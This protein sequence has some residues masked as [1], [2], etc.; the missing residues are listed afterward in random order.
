MNSLDNA[1]KICRVL[2]EALNGEYFPA[3]TGGCLYK[4]G[5][6]K[7]V[8]IVIY[9]NRECSHF[10]ISDIEDILA[11]VGFTDFVHHGFVTKCKFGMTDVD[12]FNPESSSDD[13]YESDVSRIQ[14][15][16][17]CDKSQP[18]MPV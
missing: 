9:R 15:A 11:I 1:V 16:I 17:A 3:L 13:N 10:E 4:D 12:L 14:V 6:R 18:W 2:H 7:D 8:D 5:E